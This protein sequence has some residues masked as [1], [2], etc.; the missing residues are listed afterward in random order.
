MSILKIFD[1]A[2]PFILTTKMQGVLFTD[3]LVLLKHPNSNLFQVDGT[4]I[5]VFYFDQNNKRSLSF[6]M[7]PGQTVQQ[8]VYCY[9]PPEVKVEQS[10]GKLRKTIC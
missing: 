4:N 5:E 10:S 9:P 1:Q 7:E 8:L 6:A 2:T 3:L